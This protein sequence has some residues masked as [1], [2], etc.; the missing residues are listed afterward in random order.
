M[1]VAIIGDIHGTS[2]FS[3]C[4]NQIISQDNDVD[5]IIV[6]GDWFDP[7]EPIPF[8]TMMER[9]QYFIDCCKKD[10]RIISII[11]NH[12]IEGYVIYGKT[13]R[14]AR[15]PSHFQAISNEITKN[16]NDSYLVYKIGNW[17]FS[18]AGVSKDWIE[19]IKSINPK[20]PNIL[21][22]NK[23]GWTERELTQLCS[24]YPMDFSNCGNDTH[25][26]CTWIRPHALLNS[27]PDNFNQVIGHTQVDEI[28]NLKE[29]DPDSKLKNDLWL[30]DNCRK[31][32]YLVIKIEESV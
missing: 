17:L 27:I 10:N 20:Y 4:Y 7:Y 28:V 22:S 25:Q 2:K 16:L 9:Y 29:K 18:H 1:K 6:M 3:E 13:T 15:V 26:G 11:G 30:V 24:F 19:D 14:T 5:K 31:P 12:D 23:K 8:E 21:F 32:K